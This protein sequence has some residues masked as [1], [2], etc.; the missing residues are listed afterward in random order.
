[1]KAFG[2]PASRPGLFVV[3]GGLI[4]QG[5]VRAMRPFGVPVTV[6]SA[7]EEALLRRSRHCRLITLPNTD[8]ASLLSAI[9]SAAA[10]AD[11]VPAM[12]PAG[13]TALSFAMEEASAL[14]SIVRIVLPS[15]E[16]VRT[17]LEKDRFDSYAKRCGVP[18]PRTWVFASF[19]ELMREAPHLPYPLAVKPAMSSRW[20]HPAFTNVF[21]HIK[22]LRA[23]TPAE[24]LDYAKR[25]VPVVPVPLIQEFVVGG[26]EE[27]YSYVSYRNRDGVELAGTLI[28]K[29]RLNPIRYGLGTCARVV[30]DDAM[31]AIGRHVTATLPYRSVASV[32]FKRDVRTGEARVFEV[33]GRL[34]MNFP[35]VTL[36]GVNLPW[37]MYRD[38]LGEAPAPEVAAYEGRLWSTLSHDIWAAADYRRAGELSIAGW[39]WSYRHVK[40]VLELDWRDP[41]PGVV[42]A[43]QVTRQLLRR[44]ARFF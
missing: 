38:A 24:L 43:N 20:H 10:Q 18:V 12:I 13:D 39:L 34:P 19:D 40:Q 37:L 2:A 15:R 23:D 27:H 3:G 33:N 30:R 41:G 42:F 29:M 16:A 28:Q 9:A 22:M 1:M 36:G 8:H 35:A 14:E 26:D 11:G 7:S 5:I 25:L 21:G 31:E 32:C 6:F 44:V 4:A 17:V